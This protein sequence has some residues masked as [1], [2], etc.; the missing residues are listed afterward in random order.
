M[1]TDI[2]QFVPAVAELRAMVEQTS[3]ITITDLRDRGQIERVTAARISLKKARVQIEKKGKELRE[4]AV[5]FQR[6]VITRE[7]EL[8]A[9]IAPEED[10]LSTIEGEAKQVAIMD[11]RKRK[12]PDRLAALK[13]VSDEEM[14][15]A[16]EDAINRMDDMTFQAY[17]NGRISA[18]NAKRQAD[19]DA[20]EAAIRRAEDDKRQAAEAEEREERRKA[21]LKA[22]EDRA[23][24]DGERKAR[25]EIEQRERDEKARKE[26]AEADAKAEAARIERTKKYKEFLAHH[27]WTEETKG[28]FKIEETPEGFVLYRRLGMFPKKV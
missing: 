23:R 10:R 16:D 22:A 11:E 5:A 21:D 14:E 19:L 9:I 15:S 17:L 1:N 12:L 6:A 4:D 8:I 2:E 27:G 25:E 7:K 24:A 26:R 20:R 3:E 13:E 18:R 28:D